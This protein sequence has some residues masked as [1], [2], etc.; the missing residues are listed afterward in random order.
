MKRFVY[1]LTTLVLHSYV[2]MAQQRPQY[3]QYM[4]NQFLLNPAIAGSV[5]VNDIKIG[6]RLQWLG[7]EGAPQTYNLTYHTPFKKMPFQMSSLQRGHHGT[8]LKFIG[9]RVGPITTMGAYGAYAYHHPIADN[10]FMSVGAE[11]GVMQYHI[12][13]NMLNV[14]DPND[15]KLA[16]LMNRR[17]LPDAS[18][19]VWFYG[20][21]FFGGVSVMQIFRETPFFMPNDQ[22]FTMAE[23]NAHYFITG[24][25]KIDISNSDWFLVP[26]IMYKI[27][28]PLYA[29]V[30]VNVKVQRGKDFWL[31][32]SF[33][34]DD[35][36]GLMVGMA[37][38]MEEF[39]NLFGFTYSFDFVF[40]DI[41]PY[42]GGSH[43]ITLWFQFMRGRKKVRCPDDFWN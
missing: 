11:M 13:M 36:V 25:Y 24:G 35:S 28:K 27:V 9:D 7:F 8:G 40:S 10:V 3:S 20:N 15:P 31:G 30:D 12:D 38:K 37:K 32:A 2:T 33:R 19:G 6:S 42:T 22:D 14:T 41:G 4:I 26:S 39:E 29:N 16:N 1:I 43:E 18:V 34:Q 5:D 23:L 17:V 21:K